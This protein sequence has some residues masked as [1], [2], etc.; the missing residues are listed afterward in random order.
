MNNEPIDCLIVGGGPAGLTAAIYVARFHLRAFV[1][2]A[3][4]GRASKIPCTHNLAGFP[5]GISGADLLQRMRTQAIKYGAEIVGGRVRQLKAIDDIFVA[6]TDADELAAKSVLI[7][8]GV[9]NRQPEMNDALHARALKLG[10]I[11]YCPVCDGFE[12][13]GRNVA[14]LGSGTPAAKEAVF[15]RSYTEHVTIIATSADDK[16]DAEQRSQLSHMDIRVVAGP[17]HNLKL[18]ENEINISCSAGRL[19]F[20]S[21]YP[22]LGSIVH[23]E[24]A[25][26]LGA[27]VTDEGCIMVDAHQRTK[28]P[29][30][31][32]AGDIVIELDQIS[33]AM[34]QAGVAATTIRNDLA[35]RK[36]LLW[37]A[38]SLS[39]P[40]PRGDD[41]ST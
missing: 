31:Y 22:A 20:D 24:L 7:A 5:G 25:V 2:D 23:S 9:T 29:G 39:V 15:L 19:C 40:V 36:P 8:T 37:R 38:T 28:V 34:G 13:T 17:A 4:E 6:Q 41:Y 33:H 11:R 26:T 35:A 16:L 30:L 27:E 14:V 21:I 32:A 12:V 18:E 3:G 1:V 10:R